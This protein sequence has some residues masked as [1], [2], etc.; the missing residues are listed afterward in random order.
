M[1]LL[2]TRQFHGIRGNKSVISEMRV[3][4]TKDQVHE[5][6]QI[7]GQEDEGKQ[8]RIQGADGKETWV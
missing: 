2:H 8:I 1:L 5:R 4:K 6:K 7:R 3:K